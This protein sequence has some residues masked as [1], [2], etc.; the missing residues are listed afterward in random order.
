M[1]PI[2]VAMALHS[3]F[4]AVLI[5]VAIKTRHRLGHPRAW[6]LIVS[7]LVMEIVRAIIEGANL[8]VWQNP[9]VTRALRTVEPLW[10]CL[11]SVGV[12]IHLRGRGVWGRING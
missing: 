2:S 8:T 4:L 12:L 7:A 1:L 6:I 10:A 11:L 5:F 3:F 9:D